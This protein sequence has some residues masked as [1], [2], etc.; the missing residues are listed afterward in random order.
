MVGVGLMVTKNAEGVPGQLLKVGNTVMV[1][2]IVPGEL[3]FVLL[4]AVH[5]EIC[6]T[7]DTPIPILALVFVQVKIAPTGFET[8]GLGLIVAPGQVTIGLNGPTLA[9][10]CM[11][12][13]V[14]SG[15]PTQP[16]AEGTTMYVNCCGVL[17]LLVIGVVRVAVLLPG[18]KLPFAVANTPG[19][20]AVAHAKVLGLMDELNVMTAFP[21]EQI[22]PT[23]TGEVATGIG[24]TNTVAVDVAGL[25][26]PA[27]SF[28]VKVKIAV[29]V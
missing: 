22:G 27:G 21:P 7:P 4:G 14:V 5:G 3:L 6:P 15:M 29:P 1:P 25:Q 10:G 11:M 26:G 17:V 9:T 18:D 16:L 20:T 19:G 8:K 23:V 28:V 2:T 12:M 13:V 24:F